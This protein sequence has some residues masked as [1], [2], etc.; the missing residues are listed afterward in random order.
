[1]FELIQ[2][3]KIMVVL[4]TCKNEED[5]FKMKVL[6]W[7][8]YKSMRILPD[9]QRQLTSQYVDRSGRKGLIWKVQFSKCLSTQ[10]GSDC[11]H[12][13]LVKILSKLE[14]LITK[15]I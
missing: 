5:P 10:H 9:A 3:Y 12:N 14:N 15:I 6:E 8:H 13:C 2:A 11:Y 1:M 7:S 4:V